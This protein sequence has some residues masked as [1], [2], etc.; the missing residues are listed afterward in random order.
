MAFTDAITVAV[1][2]A[3]LASTTNNLAD[4]TE[5]NRTKADVGHYFDISTGDGYHRAL[6]SAPLI[7]KA[8]ASVY[9]S[10]WLDDTDSSNIFLRFL[11]GSSPAAVTPG[12]KTSGN[13]IPI[14]SI[15]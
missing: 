9:A 11:S 15:A 2:Q 7:L 12:T 6:Y 3:V 5:F 10:L 8:S 14:A 1:G 4:N 13:I